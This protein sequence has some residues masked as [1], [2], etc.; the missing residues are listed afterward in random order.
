MATN[1][2]LNE[3]IDK[4]VNL[5]EQQQEQI[6]NLNK[7]KTVTPKRTVDEAQD[8]LPYGNKT[9]V[10]KSLK[11]SE[12]KVWMPKDNFLNNIDNRGNHN[13]FGLNK[14]DYIQFFKQ[15]RLGGNSWL[16]YDEV[17]DYFIV[18]LRKAYKVPQTKWNKKLKEMSDF[19]KAKI[20]TAKTELKKN[21]KTWTDG[22]IKAQKYK[23]SSLQNIITKIEGLHD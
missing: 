12:L 13:P 18:P 2:E 23:I 11:S 22:R 7:T 20:I 16:R 19:V 3:K 5:V 21:E 8:Y 1:K 10:L 6:N 9:T 14:G 15:H 4:L 17:I